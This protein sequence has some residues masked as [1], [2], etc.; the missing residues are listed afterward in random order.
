MLQYS[1]FGHAQCKSGEFVSTASVNDLARAPAPYALS[2][3]FID[4]SHTERKCEDCQ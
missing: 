3:I 1:P 2:S 4:V